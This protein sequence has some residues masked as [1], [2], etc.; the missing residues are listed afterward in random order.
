M[1]TIHAVVISLPFT[2]GGCCHAPLHP[3]QTLQSFRIAGVGTECAYSGCLSINS[4]CFVYRIVM[5]AL[6]ILLVWSERQQDQ[7]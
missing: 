5:Y 7:N 1:I 4:H 2:T 3:T 6:F